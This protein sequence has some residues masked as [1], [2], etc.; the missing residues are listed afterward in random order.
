MK[1]ILC[2]SKIPTT[3]VEANGE[4]QTNDEAQV[5][6]HDLDLFVTVQILDDTPAVLSPGTLRD[7]HGYTYERVS[8]KQP[9][10]TKQGKN[11]LCKT[12]N[13]VLVVVPGL[14]SS[15]SASPSSSTSTSTSSSP[16]SERSDELAP[17]N[18]S[19]NP[20]RNSIDSNDSLQRLPGLRSS[21][22]I[23]KIPKCLH[24]HTLLMTQIRSVQRKWHQ[25]STVFVLTSEKTEIAISACEPK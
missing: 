18:W 21:Q 20:A 22:K 24:P 10:W 25:G 9:R 13:F 23:S 8:G 19:R 6:V 3:V 15:S 5:Y 1:W 11:I 4:V 16:A 2:G 12:E 14:S 17:G 7:E